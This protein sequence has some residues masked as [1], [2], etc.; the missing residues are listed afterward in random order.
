[1]GKKRS[2]TDRLLA[3]T[4]THSFTGIFYTGYKSIV[5]LQ[6]FLIK[7]EISSFRVRVNLVRP[8]AIF[9]ASSPRNLVSISEM[10]LSVVAP[11]CLAVTNI[12][13][14]GVMNE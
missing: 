1:M 12:L 10:T 6:C 4:P 13:F 5:I 9:F 14:Y 3:E 7:K 11:K 2:G 8:F